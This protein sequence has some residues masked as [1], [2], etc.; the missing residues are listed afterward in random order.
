MAALTLETEPIFEVV[1]RI[2]TEISSDKEVAA[3]DSPA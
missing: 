3:R 1:Q 2:R